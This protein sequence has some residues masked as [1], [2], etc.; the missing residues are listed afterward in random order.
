MLSV[1]LLPFVF[2]ICTAI[3]IVYSLFERENPFFKQKRLGRDIKEFTLFKMRTMRSDTAEVGTHEASASSVTRLGGFLRATKLDELPQV[4]NVLV[5]DMSFVGPRP[6]L[7]T[8]T[9]LKQEREKLGIFS[10]RP[11]VTGSSQVR[12]I[13]MSNP[14]KLAKADF[15]YLQDITFFGDLKLLVA[16][17]LGEGY[18]DKVR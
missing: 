17:V 3:A 7:S 11:G 18:G 15:E 6:G 2:V 16:T 12:G 9:E 13:D 14:Y 5:G 4:W 8:Q 1:A 10:I